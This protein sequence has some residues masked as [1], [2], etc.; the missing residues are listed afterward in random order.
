MAHVRVAVRVRPLSS[1]ERREGAKII[2]NGDDR[3]VTIQDIRVPEHPG[4]DHRARYKHFRLDECFFSDGER[5]SQ[6][7][8]VYASLG[9]PL[10]DDVLAGYNGC[11]LA[12]GQSGSGKTYTMLGNPEL[13]QKLSAA[14]SECTMSLS[15]VEVYNETVRDLLMRRPQGLRVR[16]HP[17]T[18][19]YVQGLGMHLVS[20]AAELRS[21]LTRGMSRRQVGATQLNGASSR[22]HAL[23]TREG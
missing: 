11:L 5:A 17:Q 10:L 6:Q 8:Q 20:C 2:V 19:P 23:V 14:G 18:G 7:E 13:L 16:E 12:Y 9:R 4:C 1:R 15:C 3:N 22:S 21:L